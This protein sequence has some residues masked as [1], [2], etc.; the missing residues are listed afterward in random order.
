M[1]DSEGQKKMRGVFPVCEGHSRFLCASYVKWGFPGPPLPPAP[2][3]VSGCDV[4]GGS[5]TSRVS[6]CG[7]NRK[8]KG[9]LL[10]SALP[11]LSVVSRAHDHWHSVAAVGCVQPTADRPLAGRWQLILRISRKGNYHLQFYHVGSWVSGEN[12]ALELAYI[13]LMYCTD[14]HVTRP[15][16]SSCHSVAILGAS[17]VFSSQIKGGDALAFLYTSCSS[18]CL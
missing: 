13:Y 11:A 8:L 5:L 16:G 6:P 12:S 7:L 17:F 3:V 15:A 9:S 4:I 18:S 2:L 1:G 14:I 10:T